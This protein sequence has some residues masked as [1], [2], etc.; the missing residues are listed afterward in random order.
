MR[1]LAGL[2]GLSALTTQAPAAPPAAPSGLSAPNPVGPMVEL[3]WLDNSG[4]E[5]GF[6]L[7]RSTDQVEWMLAATPAMNATSHSDTTVSEGA[8]YY[9]RI[10]SVNGGGASAWSST[11]GPYLTPGGVGPPPPP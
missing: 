10:R 7:E 8:A 2:S 6:E 3:T 5:T 1:S 4:N 11:A 9:Y